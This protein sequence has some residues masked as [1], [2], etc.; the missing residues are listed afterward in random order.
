MNRKTPKRRDAGRPR[1]EPIEREILRHTVEELSKTG[2]ER[3]NVETVAR[4]A[5]V[6]KTSVYRR[7]PTKEALVLAALRAPVSNLSAPPL[8]DTGSLQGDLHAMLRATATMLEGPYGR[9]LFLASMGSPDESL[10]QLLV[11]VQDE[12]SQVS[13]QL[14]ARARARAEWRPGVASDVV[15]FALGGAA[16]HRWRIERKPLD[17]AWRA[18][19]IDLV[20]HGVAA[21]GSAPSRSSRMRSTRIS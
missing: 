1:G 12:M 21:P 15:L 9:A 2:L 10:S 19:V 7:W 8:P 14:V 20:L 11:E 18:A 5:G 3:L 13:S 16:L 17:E 6:N 4:L